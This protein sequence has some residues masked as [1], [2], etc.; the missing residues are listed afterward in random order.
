MEDPL[1]II[2]LFPVGSPGLLVLV[3]CVDQLRLLAMDSLPFQGRWLGINALV[4]ILLFGASAAQAT[5]FTVNSSRDDPDG[6]PGDGLC[7]TGDPKS[8]PTGVCT[9]RA[10]LQ[11]AQT[12]DTIVFSN[13]LQVIRPLS[14]LPGLRCAILGGQN[15][16]VTIDG[17]SAGDTHGLRI[18]YA[19]S[20]GAKI[21]SL[22]INN[23]Q[24]AGVYVAGHAVSGSPTGVIIEDCAIGT[25]PARKGLQ[26][27]G[28]GITIQGANGVV[29]RNNVISGNH[30]AGI[31]VYSN[32]ATGDY[33]RGVRITGN[34][35]GS[36]G[37]G[38]NAL[39]NGTGIVMGQSPTQ[40]LPGFNVL[41]CVIGGIDPGDMNRI[42]GNLGYEIV[43]QGDN[44]TGVPN[45]IIGNKIGPDFF[46]VF[47]R[48][49]GILLKSCDNTIVADNLITGS[50]RDGIYIT[51][52]GNN[53]ASGNV[54]EYNFIGGNFLDGIHIDEGSLLTRIGGEGA[55][56][57]ISG[58]W[59]NGIT[60]IGGSTSRH[61]IR[62]NVIVDN[63][64]L[65]ID[66][67][68]DGISHN[69]FLTPGTGPNLSQRAPEF[70]SI[71]RTNGSTV[72]RARVNSNLNPP[73][74]VEFFR[75]GACDA[76]GFG[77]G[78]FPLHEV[79]VPFNERL[80]FTVTIPGEHYALTMVSTDKAGNSSEF[81][82]CD[83]PMVV[84]STADLP[85]I[86]PGDG[87][88]STGNTLPDG[89][90]EVTLRAAIQETVH[91]SRQV[92]TILFD[93]PGD[94][95]HVIS[96]ATALPNIIRPIAIDATSQPGYSAGNPKVEV[97]GSALG[98]NPLNGLNL[99]AGET[100]IRGLTIVNFGKN[101]I[102]IQ[103][104]G[105]NVLEAN[106]I[107]LRTDGVTQAGMSES[108]IYIV[109]S[110]NNRIGGMNSA[111]RNVVTGNG[112]AGTGGAN[113]S[114]EGAG[115]TDNRVLGSYIGT[116]KTGGASPA[117]PTGADGIRLLGGASKNVIGGA[118]AAA[119]NV[120]SGNLQGIQIMD[121]TTVLNRIEGN[122]IGL[123]AAANAPVPN[124]RNGILIAGGDGN[125]IGGAAASPGSPPGNLISGNRFNGIE[126]NTD[127]NRIEGN[128]IGTSPAGS[129]AVGNGLNGILLRGKTNVIGGG[130]RRLQ[131]IISG[132]LEAGILIVGA[133]AQRNRIEG[134]LVGAGVLFAGNVAIPNQTHGIQIRGGRNNVIG[135]DQ[136]GQG[137][138]ISANKRSGILIESPENDLAN[139]AFGNRIQGNRIG[140]NAT[141][142]IALG[143]NTGI[144]VADARDNLIGGLDPEAANVI[145]GNLTD[146]IHIKG[147]GSTGNVIVQNIIGLNAPG[148][149]ALGNGANG[150]RLDAALRTV[151]GGVTPL[152][153]II[154]GNGG[155]GGGHGIQID[156]AQGAGQ[157]N[158]AHRIEGNRIGVTIN[159]APAANRGVGLRI[160]DAS[161]NTVGPNNSIAHNQGVG[162]SV[163]HQARGEGNLITANSIHSNGL[164][165]ID[166]G[167]DGVTLNDLDDA[168][169]GA[170][171]L[172]NF[173]DLTV[174][175]GVIQ[176]AF[177]HLHS[178]PN[179]PF[180]VELYRN[181]NADSS[182]F[183]EG[184]T[185]IDSVPLMTDALGHARSTR[186]LPLLGAGECVSA[187]AINLATRDTSE[188]SACV[189]AQPVSLADFGDAPGLRHGTRFA[190]DGARH[191]VNPAIRL[192]ALIDAEA[193]ATVNALNALGDDADH[194]ADEDGVK[195]LT[196]LRAGTPL[197]QI[198][199]QASVPGFLN[200]W[201]DLNANGDFS[202]PAEHV[203]NDAVLVAGTNVLHLTIPAVATTG[204]T[205]ARF[206]FSTTPGVSFAGPAQDGEVEDYQVSIEDSGTIRLAS[207]EWVEGTLRFG[208]PTRPG[209]KYQV[210]FKASLGDPDWQPL[211]GL[212]VGDG[213]MNIFEEP[214]DAAMRFYRLFITAP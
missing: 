143:N 107:G 203:I 35:I 95:P 16:S 83:I 14:A 162:V 168:D 169:A 157:T 87:I 118:T 134:N 103:G 173:P 75:N 152:G 128:V 61:S 181:S 94:G 111:T 88:A 167:G 108:G 210:Q 77:Q 81:S 93:I 140:V 141:G 132:N 163:I 26:S 7:D 146:G 28:T 36:D 97:N 89:R 67:G 46:S 206:R 155:A 29:I 104:R 10:A 194:L 2:H 116:D 208:W 186:L 18:E 161:G 109:N 197:P 51:T 50:S 187:I 147:E 151:I 44:F 22:V 106:F 136:V 123:N 117:N 15:P 204:I 184:E 189:A 198:Q 40:F 142:M 12:G 37:T 5:V 56:N 54:V 38:T 180:R 24:R 165:G 145:S 63:L 52:V 193:D 110:T 39:G 49:W 202:E 11:I 122:I 31:E 175:G 6:N 131:N 149:L 1:A 188:F 96:P 178:T 182:G 119:G 154:S 170:N 91:P 32:I 102:F 126:S 112:K 144:T 30:D 19:A 98:Q 86:N 59:N 17:S 13:G 115:A 76:R 153:N 92:S 25:G 72:V 124:R 120:I 78:E 99:L 176:A 183:G 199:V 64:A 129:L 133:A 84:N 137:N 62:G 74:S 45:K 212:V 156:G 150:I 20:S 4:T 172:Q 164:L 73:F 57:V 85:D 79:T 48:G 179:T 42:S 58:N 82:T 130:D 27:N 135:G 33:T 196:P 101:G 21:S 166:L 213:T 174:Y 66:L 3:I 125:R 41:D 47:G 71:Q 113:I 192:G 138:L 148:R 205:Y 9:L 80:N 34:I 191:I 207:A 177:L 171:R 68:D 60:I 65:G 114:I 211:G 121:V 55:G 201:I 127:N 200:A 190:A 8:G 43:I 23:F 159:G 90:L 185:L 195:F 214:T 100:A 70:L 160:V 158:A 105:G 209:W 53:R 139:V 69:R